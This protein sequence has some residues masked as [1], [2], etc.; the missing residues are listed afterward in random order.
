M[1]SA[2]KTKN[3]F[4]IQDLESIDLKEPKKIIFDFLFR[5]VS[6][7]SK[8]NMKNLTI[9]DYD[10][11][12][13][14]TGFSIDL[15]RN[16]LEGFF[17]DFNNFNSFISSVNIKWEHSL[18]KLRVQLRVFLHRLYRLA[19]MF[20]YKRAKKNLEILHHKFS[21]LHYWPSITTQLAVLI[22]VTDK[23][24][25][26]EIKKKMHIQKNI[27]SLCSCSAYSFHQARNRLNIS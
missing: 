21:L 7:F 2:I 25:S 23:N 19:P 27:Y 16:I 15:V 10:I 8:N 18:T 24:E 26:L 3:Y 22:Y 11:I 14:G 20:N 4:T 1:S 13:Q 9:K 17:I 12:T 6:L 5:N